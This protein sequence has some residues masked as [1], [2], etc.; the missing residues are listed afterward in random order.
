MKILAIGDF[1]GRLSF[2][3]KAKLRKENFDMIIGLGD[4]AGIK[5]W[6][7]WLRTAFISFSKGEKFISAEEF[8]GKKK[9]KA[10]IRRDDM[11]GR[12]ILKSI[13]RFKK[14]F[15]YIWGNGDDRFYDYPFYDKFKG[16][17]INKGFVKNL[18]KRQGIYNITY[19]RIK[20]NNKW[21]VGFGGF[22]D[23]RANYR[24]KEKKHLEQLDI[25]VKRS[26]RKF[27]EI[28][29]PILKDKKS[30]RVFVFHYRT[31]GVFDMIRTKGNPF[32]GNSAGVDFFSSAIRKHKPCLVLCGHM[33]EYQGAKMFGK[34]LVVNPGDAERDKYAIIDL[35]EGK[36]EKIK[37]RFAR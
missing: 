10:L 28:I 5:E 35:P 26:K 32:K 16:T 29:K 18:N 4:Y 6:N 13:L 30:D 24:N 31:K 14:P 12:G 15:V 3:L 22:M 8:Y 17:K 21:F 33:H 9:F 11:A 36:N 27:E 37:V 23:V 34:S 25:R 7:D 19:G 20:A 2:K 1:Q